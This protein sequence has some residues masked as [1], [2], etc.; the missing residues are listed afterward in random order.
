MQHTAATTDSSKEVLI[1]ELKSAWS[2]INSLWMTEC[3]TARN[4]NSIFCEVAWR[5]PSNTFSN[6]RT[7]NIRQSAKSGKYK[8]LKTL[9]K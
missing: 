9:E 6:V 7:K 5:P 2:I 3:N 4:K 8:P 1:K